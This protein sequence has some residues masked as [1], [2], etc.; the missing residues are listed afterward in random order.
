MKIPFDHVDRQY[1]Y[2]DLVKKCNAT[3]MDRIAAYLQM[4]SYYLFGSGPDREP[5]DFNKINSH[6]DLL[7]SFLYASE[8]TRFSIQFDS[9]IPEGE[10]G[11]A[12]SMS[13]SLARDWHSSNM[14]ILYGL[15]LNWALAYNS[16]FI[17]LIWQD[18]LRGYL[19]EPHNVG[20]LREDLPFLD[21]QEAITH[22]YSITKSELEYRLS[23]HPS[24]KEILDRVIAG[25]QSESVIPKT[26]TRLIDL[27]QSSPNL[28]G[29]TDLALGQQMRYVPQVV[30]DMIEMVE[31]W[32]YNDDIHEYQVVTLAHP[33]VVIYDREGSSLFLPGEQPLVQICP[34]PLYDYF[35][36]ESEVSKLVQLQDM[37]NLR[38]AQ[39]QEL[40]DKHVHPAHVM[41]GFMGLYDEKDFAL[42]RPGGLLSSDIPNAQAKA[43]APE[44]PPDLYKE[45]IEIDS[46][47]DEVVGLSAVLKGRGETGVRS[48]GHAAELAHLGSARAKKRALVVED[49]L[50]KVA[51]LAL[52]LKRHYDDRSLIDEHGNKYIPEQFPEAAIVKI[53]AHSNSPIFS[54][55]YRS[56]A[57]ILFKAHAI[58]RE[59][60][61]DMLQP[62]MA[63]TLKERLNTRIIPAE[64]AAAKAQAAAAQQKQ[65]QKPAGEEEAQE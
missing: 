29:N 14:D 33:D 50:E 5:A 6:I 54:E 44:L 55:D 60:L 15:G 38:V 51:T 7:S 2:Y 48:R 12:V 30:E 43:I 35:W 64:Q 13:E 36:G 37:R 49:S 31:L 40:L 63:K 53:D 34:N 19:V 4:R 1:F 52:K 20:V 45:I 46:M 58:D 39:I 26:I 42:N 24:R 28:I 27:S 23:S 32:V 10:Y 65:G 21:Q 22:S 17:K 3:R 61:L 16:M 57:E 11:K 62:P 9:G 47:F 59:S 25:R 8:T 41:S 18:G 56:L